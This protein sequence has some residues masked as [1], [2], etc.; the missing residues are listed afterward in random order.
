MDYY[1]CYRT[2]QNN[3]GDTPIMAEEKLKR[4]SGNN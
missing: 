3:G 4:L 1:N 2:Q